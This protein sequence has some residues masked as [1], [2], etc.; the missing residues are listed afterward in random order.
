MS[1]TCPKCKNETESKVFCK[2]CEK[3]ITQEALQEHTGVKGLD[4]DL[5]DR[6]LA[7]K[8]L[9][10]AANILNDKLSRKAYYAFVPCVERNGKVV[11]EL[12]R[13][14]ARSTREA[15]ITIKRKIRRLN[16]YVDTGQY[17]IVTPRDNLLAVTGIGQPVKNYPDKNLDNDIE[18]TNDETEVGLFGCKN[19]ELF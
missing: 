7:G 4:P 13:V 10:M 19:R 6:E 17:H 2:L 16:Q 8:E 9:L 1:R 15:A 12:I 11:T 3:K 14:S 18:F 5:V